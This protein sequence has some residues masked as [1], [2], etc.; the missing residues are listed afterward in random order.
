MILTGTKDPDVSHNT[1]PNFK[2]N[3]SEPNLKFQKHRSSYGVS[4]KFLLPGHLFSFV[5][6]D[7]PFFNLSDK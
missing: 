7:R 3:Q 1:R 6:A 2:Q 5:K 4:D